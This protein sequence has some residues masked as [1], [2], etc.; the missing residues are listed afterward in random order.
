[1]KQ[2]SSIQAKLGPKSWS[3]R[4]CSKSPVGRLLYEG[5]GKLAISVLDCKSQIAPVDSSLIGTNFTT[6]VH[7]CQE[8]V[9]RIK[10][11]RRRKEEIR[12]HSMTSSLSP[13]KL[14]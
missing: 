11:N 12:K 14:P 4:E 10:E 7:V 13:L 5:V 8:C 6:Q 2:A 1:M 9:S 3:K